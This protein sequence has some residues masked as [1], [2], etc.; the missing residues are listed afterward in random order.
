MTHRLNDQRRVERCANWHAARARSGVAE[1]D[2]HQCEQFIDGN[3]PIAAAIAD[4]RNRRLLDAEHAGVGRSVDRCGC[5]RVDGER[6]DTC[7]GEAGVE[8]GPARTGIVA[9]KHAGAVIPA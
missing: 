1:R 2:V 7:A 8:P 4:A 9:F 3:A 5:V 6:V